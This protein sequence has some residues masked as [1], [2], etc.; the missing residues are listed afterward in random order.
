MDS[1]AKNGTVFINTSEFK[2]NINKDAINQIDSKICIKCKKTEPCNKLL[3]C[4]HFKYNLTHITC[5]ESE[6]TG[7][8]NFKCSECEN[9]MMLNNIEN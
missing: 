5:F 3:L 2:I 7:I 1:K 9:N 8:H 6:S 4:K